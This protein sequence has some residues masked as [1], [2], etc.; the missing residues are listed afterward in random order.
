[1][2][3]AVAGIAFTALV[4]PTTRFAAGYQTILPA[5]AFAQL[6]AV[7]TPATSIATRAHSALAAVVVAALGVALALPLY[8]EF[9]YPSLRQ[10]HFDSWSDRKRGDPAV[11]A[12]NSDWW[13]VPNR[14]DYREAFDHARAVDFDYD[15]SP[16]MTC[17]N[18]PQPCAS[19]PQLSALPQVR[20]RDPQRGPAG[21]FVRAR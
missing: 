14:I 19:N 4:A 10:R 1:V 5:L 13:L 20:L 3:I 17:W 11:N 18:H 9:V 2:A 15:V 6:T 7:G 8:K 16:R 21:G 12:L